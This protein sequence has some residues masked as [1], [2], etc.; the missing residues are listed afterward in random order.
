MEDYQPF[1]FGCGLSI[2]KERIGF[3]EI[4]YECYQCEIADILLTVI[5]TLDQRLRTSKGKYPEITQRQ[6]RGT[7]MKSS[8]QNLKKVENTG[9]L[10]FLLR[11]V[12]C[13]EPEAQ[14][15]N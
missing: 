15:V 1:H 6:N 7:H 11:K 3:S 9:R 14:D 4:Q 2:L 8:E 5:Q 13:S 12:R 10:N